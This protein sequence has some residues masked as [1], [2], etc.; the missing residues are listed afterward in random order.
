MY[1]CIPQRI[2]PRFFASLEPSPRASFVYSSIPQRITPRFFTSLE[3]SPQASFVCSSIPQHITPCFFASFEPS[4]PASLMHPIHRSS[5]H[6]T[7]LYFLSCEIH[8]PMLFY[9]VTYIHALASPYRRTAC[10]LS[11]RPASRP[12]LLL[13]LVLLLPLRLHYHYY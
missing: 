4:P 7:Y 11:A 12:A 5:Q 6:C 8:D 3:P 1:S 10:L 2:T 13:L 9:S